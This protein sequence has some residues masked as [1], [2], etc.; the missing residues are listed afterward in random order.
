MHMQE[1]LKHISEFERNQKWLR[2]NF[3]K[4]LKKY[5]EQFVAVFGE[6]IIDHDEN[7]ETL[8]KRVKAKTKGAKGI[9]IGYIS[10]K[11][12]EMIL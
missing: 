3:E 5:R 6:R 2:E 1:C 4:L 7:L 10:D 8:V 12:I 11:P 9:Y